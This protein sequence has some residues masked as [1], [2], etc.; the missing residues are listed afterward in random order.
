MTSSWGPKAKRNA[1]L[2]LESIMLGQ[3]PDAWKKTNYGNPEYPIARKEQERLE[4]ADKAWR[5]ILEKL[6]IKRYD[7]TED[8]AKVFRYVS[9]AGSS[10]SSKKNNNK[11]NTKAPRDTGE[12]D[13]ILD[14]QKEDQQAGKEVAESF[15]D[16]E[17]PVGGISPELQAQLDNLTLANANLTGQL[18]ERDAYWSNTVGSINQA[19]QEAINELNGQLDE[20]ESY[21]TSTVESINQ[22][23]QEAMDRLSERESY[24]TNTVESIN[25]ANREAMGRMETMMLQQQQSAAAQQQLLTS[26]LTSTQ[27]ALQEQQRMSANLRNAYVPAAEQSAQSASYGDQRTTTRRKESNSLNDLSIVTGVGSSNS[28]SGL[29]LA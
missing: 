24:W 18:D 10:S 15:E 25:Q 19:N 4:D 11:K 21:W 26:Q 29:T 28:L 16:R 7:D 14:A 12:Y 9:Q 23:N 6:K 1:D 5:K 13:D 20:R 17:I 22:A 27:N 3:G 8:K 2:V